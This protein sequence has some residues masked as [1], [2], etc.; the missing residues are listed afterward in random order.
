MVRS[1]LKNKK[2]AIRCPVC[3]SKNTVGVVLTYESENWGNTK[4]CYFCSEC[5]IEFN[6]THYK[7]FSKK[8]IT[9]KII[10]I[11]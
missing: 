9:T 2:D 10:S 3:H 4:K 11:E 5:F 7:Y 1:S 6:D 8:G